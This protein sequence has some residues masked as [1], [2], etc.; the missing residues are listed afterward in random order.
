[1]EGSPLTEKRSLE[2]SSSIHQKLCAGTKRGYNFDHE[3]ALKTMAEFNQAHLESDNLND[4]QK[5]ILIDNLN[6][7]EESLSLI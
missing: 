2:N 1:M 5:V 4:E 7:K 6:S 3:K